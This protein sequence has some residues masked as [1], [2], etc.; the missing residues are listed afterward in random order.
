MAACSPSSRVFVF[1]QAEDGI[2]VLTVTG[3]QTCALPICTRGIALE[4]CQA[5]VSIMRT[6]HSNISRVSPPLPRPI[7]TRGFI[8]TYPANFPSDEIR[9]IG[10]ASCR[11]R[12]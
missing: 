3:V 7:T 12:V 2:R 10:R 1:F 9:E 5:D 4:S 8:N 6:I 11:E